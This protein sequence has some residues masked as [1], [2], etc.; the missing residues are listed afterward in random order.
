[1]YY[2][3]LSAGINVICPSKIVASGNRERYDKVREAE[4]K[5]AA[6]WQYESSVGSALPILT[7]LRD[8]QQTGDTVQ[9]I[10]GSASGTMA[11]CLRTHSKDTKFSE[12]VM[13]A[14]EKGFTE[15]DCREDLSGLDLR[16]KVVILAREIGMDIDLEDVEVDAVLPDSIANKKYEG[17][18][19]EISCAVAEDIKEIDDMM[20][21][22]LEAALAEDKVLRYKFEIDVESNTCKIMLV[23]VDNKDPLYRLKTDENL[24]AF[25]TQRY[26][27]SPLIVKGSAAGA[28]LAASGI[29]ADLL[30]LSRAFKSRDA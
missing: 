19:D 30:R 23:A 11:H 25:H 22:K 18:N 20:D 16:R 26:E 27:F 15:P 21:K 5:N 4:K 3:W 7:T 1:M 12:A 9:R 2:K 8:L 28:D 17:S 29:F 14:F 10:V 13:S 6:L 24:V